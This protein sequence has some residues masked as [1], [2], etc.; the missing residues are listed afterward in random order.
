MPEERERLKPLAAAF[1]QEDLLRIFEAL[2][3]SEVDLREAEDPR[4]TLELT[5]MKTAQLQKLMPFTELVDRVERL[6]GGAPVAPRAP[7]AREP[8]PS[9]PTRAA[10]P[11]PA[12]AG[13]RAVPAAAPE[14][15]APAVAAPPTSTPAAPP[16]SPQEIVA[17]MLALAQTR[18]SIAQPLRTATARDDQ[19]VLV[20]E[21]GADF[22]AMAILNQ[23]E[24]RQ[25]AQ[26]AS[27][28]PTKVRIE[29]LRAAAAPGAPDPA[30][31]AQKRQRALDEASRE[32]AVQEALDLFNGKVVD[33]RKERS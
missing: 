25:L 16:T 19:G 24:Y 9:V 10:T 32:P 26:K 1:S 5:L 31:A 8:Q 7:V 27:G 2:T 22:G 13:P 28:R 11:P 3:K 23:D 14:R 21:V 18:P 17:A 20:I 30:D 4:V 33:V 6:A 29:T 15:A 12:P